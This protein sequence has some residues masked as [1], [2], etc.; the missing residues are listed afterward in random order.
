MSNLSQGPFRDIVSNFAKLSSSRKLKFQYQPSGAGGTRPPPATP[1]CLQ[2][3]KLPP[4]G[5]NMVE[6]VWK[7]VIPQVIG[8]F[9]PLSL[10]KIFDPST[11]SMRN[12]EHLQNPKWPPGGPKMADGVWK[13]VQPQ[14]IGHFEPLSQNKFFDPSTPSMRNIEHLQN[15]KWPPGGPK[16]AD[17]VW[18]WV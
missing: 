2:N 13:G 4:V 14:V 6:V 15:P 17:V 16:M 11:P 9:E 10:N 5:P 18:K 12:I 3:P 8:H 7:G 1:H